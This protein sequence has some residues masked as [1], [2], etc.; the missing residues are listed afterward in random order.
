MATADPVQQQRLNLEATKEVRRR[1]EQH[2]KRI[3]VIDGSNR[4]ALREWLQN[5]DHAAAWTGANDGLLLEMVGYLATGGLAIQ[6]R[7]YIAQLAAGQHASWGGVKAGIEE[8][9]LNEDER[10]YLRARVEQLTQNPYEDSREYGRRYREAVGRAYDPL[11]LQVPLVRDRLAKQYLH[12]LRDKA[13][14]TQVFMQRP[15]GVDAAI[16]AANRTA[17]AVG[18][19]EVGGRQEEPMEIGALPLHTPPMPTMQDLADIKQVLKTLQGEIKS[20]RKAT[21]APPRQA[22]EPPTRRE[23]RAPRAPRPGNREPRETPRRPGPRPQLTD[24][25]YEC[26]EPG[27]FARDCPL[28]RRHVQQAVQDVMEQMSGQGN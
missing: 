6:I 12:G 28:R 10:E 15:V 27:H 16:E 9:F 14:R 1:L 13:V 22:E 17:H 5:I 7:T 26:R 2:A 20:L 3:G 23:Q 25:C 18:L 21:E 4:E 24:G 8:A 19:A 11:D